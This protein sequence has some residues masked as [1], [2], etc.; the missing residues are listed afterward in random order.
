MSNLVGDNLF[1]P[2]WYGM[3]RHRPKYIIWSKEY[4]R[5][6]IFAT[7]TL[8]PDSYQFLKN[9]RRINMRIELSMLP[10]SSP[11]LMIG[12][13]MKAGSVSMLQFVI[14]DPGPFHRDAIHVWI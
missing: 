13:K 7:P 5:L 1:Q 2:I 9:F 12:E 14:V 8:Q 4:L 3:L 6:M 11:G 10:L